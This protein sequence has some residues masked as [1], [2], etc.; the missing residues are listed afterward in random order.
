MDKKIILFELNEVPLR[1]IDQFCRW[2][3][4][5]A[6]ARRI[7][8][9]HQYETFTEDV[10]HLSP[11]TT[12]PTLHRGVPDTRH[13]IANFGQDMRAV[14]QEF[15][16]LW[17]L[18]AR[19][20]V[21]T[22]VCGSLHSYPLP[23]D[24]NHY[25]FYL[26]DTFAA[27]SECFPGGLSAFQDFNLRMARESALNVSEKLP[28]NTALSLLAAA[29]GLGLRLQTLVD[30]GVQLVSE[31]MQAWRKIRR[32]TYQAVLAFDVFMKQLS[33]TTPDFVSFFTNHVASS[34][35]RY[36]AAAFP[37]DYQ[38]FGFD[39]DWVRTFS[40]EIQFTMQKFD[41]M[42]GR[43]VQ[44]VDAHPEYNLWITTSMGQAATTALPVETALLVTD[45]QRFMTALGL[46][47][48]D[49]RRAPAM[50]PQFNVT[51]TRG[52]RV[53]AFRKALDSVLIDGHPL[54]HREAEGNFFSI[55]FGHP[56]LHL[57]PPVAVCQGRHVSFAEMGLQA[58]PIDDKSGATAYHVPQGSLLIYDPLRRAAKAGR[59]QVSTL[60][61]APTLLRN[62]A[63]PVPA[64][65]R[66]PVTLS[67]AA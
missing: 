32:R 56:N 41:G 59:T 46:E 40:H 63:V 4:R 35:H 51:I 62:Y 64:Y 49:W 7:G 57:V 52:D 12:W 2:S 3:P 14:N 42:F 43:L 31:R 15:P 26:P 37:T 61:I 23:A 60:E 44:F 30:V 33:A 38:Q 20:G 67:N 29:P 6:L 11:W 39:S 47:S 50:V 21:Q 36:W 9:C 28:W 48:T 18:L 53:A 8:D 16:P 17:E 34:L 54:R 27:G 24:L 25:A 10:G 45:V 55:D 22:G 5:S 13:L 58:V 65:M 66:A 1:V 19:H